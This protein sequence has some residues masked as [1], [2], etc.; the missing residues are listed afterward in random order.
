MAAKRE[1]K[2]NKPVREEKPETKA[3]DTGKTTKEIVKKGDTVIIHYTGMLEDGTVFDS[4]ERHQELLKF[5]VGAGQ[6]IKGFEDAAIG[7]KK[8]QEKSIT[9]KPEEGYG[10][11][12]PNM[13]RKINRKNLPPEQEPKVGMVIV[14]GF[15]NGMEFPAKITDVNG[16]IVTIDLN[17]PL[18]GKTLNFKLKVVDIR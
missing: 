7:M 9:I 13:V 10:M 4:S 12:D 5:E 17:H 16:D 3:P 18:A 6:V 1:K 11:P 8:D 15:N 14:L 2:E